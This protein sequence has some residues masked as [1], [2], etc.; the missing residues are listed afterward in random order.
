MAE[1]FQ[2]EV[3]TLM[4]VE[5]LETTRVPNLSSSYSNNQEK[6]YSSS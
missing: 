6:I 1:K 4:I 5:Q 3:I 2:V